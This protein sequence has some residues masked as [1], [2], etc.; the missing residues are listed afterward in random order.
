MCHVKLKRIYSLFCIFLCNF[1][2]FFQLLSTNNHTNSLVVKWVKNYIKKED[3]D[4]INSPDKMLGNKWFLQ[5]AGHN[6][7]EKTVTGC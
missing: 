2:S 3:I 1:S 6:L 5:I 4:L 7:I